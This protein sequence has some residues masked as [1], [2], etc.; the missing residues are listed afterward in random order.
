VN[1]WM[2]KMR[3][4]P[5]DGLRLFKALLS[6]LLGNSRSRQCSKQKEDRDRTPSLAA[7]SRHNA[8]HETI[9]Q[10]ESSM[11]NY[12]ERKS[13]KRL[14]FSYLHRFELTQEQLGAKVSRLLLASIY[15][16]SS[17]VS[18]RFEEPMETVSPNVIS[19]AAW[20]TIY[21]LLGPMG[22]IKMRPDYRDIADEVESELM[23]S[24]TGPET[25]NTI[26][27]QVFSILAEHGLCHPEVTALIEACVV[28]NRE[29]PSMP[30][31][32]TSVG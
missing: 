15:A 8:R 14:F 29:E 20:G 25:E 4:K 21:C 11:F 28:S 13:E 9:N 6:T 22:M 18:R 31:Q 16:H 32:L 1:A 12:L 24:Y 30:L 3:S 26:Y 2:S 7:D 5:N 27:R 19:T 17:E 10:V 23:L